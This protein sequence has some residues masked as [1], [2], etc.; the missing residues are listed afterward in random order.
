MVRNLPYMLPTGWALLLSG[1]TILFPPS[2]TGDLRF[3]F[4][5]NSIAFATALLEWILAGFAFGGI[6]A[7]LILIVALI[8]H[9]LSQNKIVVFPL[10]PD[11]SGGF[12]PLG[13][14]SLRLSYLAAGLGLFLVCQIVVAII[15][16]RIQQ[17]HILMLASVLYLVAVPT[18]FYLPLH[19]THKAML[20][21]RDNLIRDTSERY[22][23]THQ[24]IHSTNYTLEAKQLE[25]KLLIL[26]ALKKLQEEHERAYPVWPFNINIRFAVLANVLTPIIPT[27]I[28]LV[29][30]FATR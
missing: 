22:L 15:D 30:D 18:F 13:N 26:E 12:S 7:D 8:S 21:Y 9:T 1:Y 17:D 24:S 6:I 3:W 14:F 4:N 28:G 23:E 10:H 11:R 16:R 2:R 19:S 25:E 27:I 5:T 20:A 29:I